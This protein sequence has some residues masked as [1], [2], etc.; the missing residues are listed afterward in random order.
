MFTGVFQDGNYGPP[1]NLCFDPAC[2]DDPVMDFTPLEDNNVDIIMSYFEEAVRSE[3]KVTKGSH[4]S[5][6]LGSDFQV[7]L[8]K[9]P[10]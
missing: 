3:M 7:I 9:Q 8:T 5:F 2:G 10:L 4:I 6:R 1:A